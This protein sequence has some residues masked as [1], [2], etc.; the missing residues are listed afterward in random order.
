MWMGDALLDWL[1]SPLDMIVTFPMSPTEAAFTCDFSPW[2][3]ALDTVPLRALSHEQQT[4]GMHARA[5]NIAELWPTVLSHP[6]CPV[7]PDHADVH[8]PGHWAQELK[9]LKDSQRCSSCALI[10]LPMYVAKICKPLIYF[11]RGLC[12]PGRRRPYRFPRTYRIRS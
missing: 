10:K 5:M 4:N 12:T 2:M 7:F 8:W 1:Y 9:Q 3:G 11:I 6:P